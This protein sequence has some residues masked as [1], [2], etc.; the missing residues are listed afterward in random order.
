VTLGKEITFAE[1]LLTHSAKIL[2]LCRVSAGLHSAK[3]QS[4]GPFVSFFAEC[5]R[6]HS[7]KLASL[8]SVKVTTLGIEALPVPRCSFSTEYTSLSILGFHEFNLAGHECGWTHRH[9]L[10]RSQG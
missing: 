10:T 3:G 2:L 5:A 8:P 9:G 1:Y 6:R 7:A 4:A